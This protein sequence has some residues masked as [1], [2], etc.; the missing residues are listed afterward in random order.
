M[1][2]Q[3]AKAFF[4]I[5]AAS[6]LLQN[7]AS[8]YGMQKP[9][10]FAR[11]FI[12]GETVAEAIDA[13]RAIESRG[14]LHTLDFLGEGVTSLAQADGATREYLQIIDAIIQSGIGRNLSL[15]LT[16]L[17]LDVDRASAVDNLRRILDRAEGFFV[18]IDMENSRYTEVTL[19]VFETL[20]QQDYRH[21]GVVLQADLYRTEQDARRM[22]ALGA[23]IRLVKGAYKEPKSIAY[24]KK[25]DVNAAYVR[26]LKLLLTEGHYPA[27]AT[28]D[29]AMLGLA[30]QF[31]AEHQIPSEAF[32]FQML[33]GI[34]R[35][36]QATLLKQGYRVR[37]YIPF[38]RQWFPYFMRRLG[39]RPANVSFV[40]R[41]IAGERA[42]SGENG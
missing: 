10:S 4:H 5:L 37:V 19:D 9:A 2:D 31:T 17:G 34:R 29:P 11:R 24:Q 7:L 12:A 14:F 23:R 32:E 8:R 18:R 36:L 6:S 1:L 28:H 25:S 26:L 15:K 13:A 21:M 3:A 35:D 42:I 33:Y 22:L 30:R 40:L 41:G 38:G 16:Q 39:E 27:I 20:W